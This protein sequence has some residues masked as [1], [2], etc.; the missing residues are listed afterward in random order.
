M[1]KHAFRPSF[2]EQINHLLIRLFSQVRTEHY[3]V[4]LE[5]AALGCTSQFSCP[6]SSKPLKHKEGTD[7]LWSVSHNPLQP[8]ML[9]RSFC[10]MRIKPAVCIYQP[11]LPDI[12]HKCKVQL[13]WQLFQWFSSVSQ[14]KNAMQYW[15]CSRRQPLVCPAKD[16]SKVLV[17]LH[18]GLS[19]QT[20]REFSALDTYN[21][22]TKRK[23]E[24]WG[25]LIV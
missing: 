14:C 23:K 16:I 4:T 21:N 13:L 24:R 5:K 17:V 11:T 7:T 9:P 20:R 2:K 15:K 10:W 1:V 6:F 25:H 12:P 22:I 18:Q 8:K 3:F 19:D